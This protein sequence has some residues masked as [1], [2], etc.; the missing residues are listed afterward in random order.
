[1]IFFLKKTKSDVPYDI[2]SNF[3]N[4]Q[5]KFPS[6]TFLVF[7][8]QENFVLLRMEVNLTPG[9][10]HVFRNERRVMVPWFFYLYGFKYPLGKDTTK[11]HFGGIYLVIL[12]ETR[13]HMHKQNM[14]NILIGE[15][16]I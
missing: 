1:M 2:I 4:I 7:S 16:K 14:D 3:I 15:G 10:F 6:T 11:A 12:E 13:H 9:R 8:F 5:S